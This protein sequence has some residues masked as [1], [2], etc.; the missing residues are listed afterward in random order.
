MLLVSLFWAATASAAVQH[1][2]IKSNL[3]LKPGEAQTITVDATEPTEIGWKAV[4]P[5]PCTTDCVQASEISGGVRYSMAT[6]L[7]MS[8]KYTPASGKITIEYK[9]VS[10]EP[11]AID[12]FRIHRTC[13]AEGCKFLQADDK[14]RW[15]VF[16]V[17][18]FKSISTSA[19]GSYSLISGVTITGKPFTVRALWWT[20]DKSAPH[21]DCA[22]FVKR[23]VDG[24]T[25]KAKYSPYVISGHAV[26][27]ASPIVLRSIDT[28]APRA[29]H[30]GVP[31][32]NVYK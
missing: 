26:G 3:P 32:Q 13:D 8:K 19:D 18:E 17:D 7:G 4:Q 11:V 1:I 5:K 12:V 23:F 6:K 30:F 21:V 27:S 20:D 16:K 25:P 29:T 9:N 10:S 24:R 15:L 28:C 31:E 14:G 2:A 22:P